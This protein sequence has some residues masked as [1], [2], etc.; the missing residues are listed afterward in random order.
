MQLNE[1][2]DWY[3]LSTQLEILTIVRLSITF[4]TI[5]IIRNL[6]YKQ[7]VFIE[8]ICCTNSRSAILLTSIVKY[9][10]GAVNEIRK[11]T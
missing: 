2:G 11:K 5:Y 8:H 10:F 4:E 7:Q 9:Q 6:L 1:T 3:K